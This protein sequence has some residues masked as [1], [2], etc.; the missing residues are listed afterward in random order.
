MPGGVGFAAD[1]QRGAPRPGETLDHRRLVD[2][3]RQPHGGEIAVADL[4]GEQARERLADHQHPRRTGGLDRALGA[5][6]L[7]VEVVEENDDY[8]AVYETE[9][10]IRNIRPDFVQLEQLSPFAVAITAPAENVDFVS[11]YFAPS[12]GI[13]EDPV[14]GSV[15]CALAPYWAKRLKK[16]RLHARQVSERGGELWC[17]TAGERVILKGNAVLTMEGVLAI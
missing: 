16:T 5:R 10:A 8:I 15:H 6:P 1:E 2:E 12:Y 17:D 14:T 4:A 13:P 9:G 7:S 3:R 11:R